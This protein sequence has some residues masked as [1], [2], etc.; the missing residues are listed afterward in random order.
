MR[1]KG[2]F[3]Q[4]V[5]FGINFI[6]LVIL[7]IGITKFAL[8]MFPEIAD[9]WTQSIFFGCLLILGALFAVITRIVKQKNGKRK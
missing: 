9:T 1:R 2:S 5:I 8:Q 6:I 7:S 3:K 4:K